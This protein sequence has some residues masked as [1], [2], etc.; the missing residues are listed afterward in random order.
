MPNTYLPGIN[1]TLNDLGL[2]IAPPPAGPKVTLLGITSNTGVTI[3]EPFTVTSLEK[4]MNT[5]YF[6]SGLASTTR[7]P[8][9]L[10]LAL[11]QANNA[12]ATNLEV[13]VIGH[14]TGAALL[15]YINPTGIP[16]QRYSDLSGA[17][18]I[19]RNRDLDV[20]VPINAWI[21]CTGI[22]NSQNF[23]KQ[24]ANFCFQA[25]QE[26]NSCIGVISVRPPLVWAAANK[27]QLTSSGSPTTLSGEVAT[28]FPAGQTIGDF[29][30]TVYFGSPSSA[31]VN[32]WHSYHAYPNDLSKCQNTFLGNFVTG[33]KYDPIYA[34]WLSGAADQNDN[35]LSEI[36]ATASAVNDAYFT[37]WQAYD[38]DG[39]AAVDSRSIKVDAGAYISVFT[40]PVAATSSTLVSNLAT[41]L[42]A[43]PSVTVYNTG[44]EAGYAGL[45]N[46]LAPQSSTTN[47]LVSGLRSVKLLSARQANDLSGM[48]HVTMYSRS[49][50]F[51][52][53]AG[54][55]GAYKVTNYIRSD[56]VNLTTVRIVHAVVDTI[57]AI[58][59]KYLGEPNN[60]PQLNALDNEV[61]QVLNTFKGSGALNSADYSISST[62]DQ[63]VLGIVEINLTLVPAFEIRT[64]NLTVSLSKD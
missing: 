1:L 15:T 4:A 28:L 20:V 60:A 59:E 51:V 64:I 53:G 16:S 24:L 55:T 46:S 8:G 40:A 37:S 36:P 18:D 19:L 14:Y 3:R 6:Q 45:V 25:T 2:K 61:D 52:V 50:G 54:N 57:R 21:D 56:Y 23:G 35:T 43:T 9:E 11:E 44:G 30:K 13:I 33:Y 29:L 27:Q 31:L 32:E 38:S 39:V 63:R 34:G 5:L 49:K 26:S 41:S 62:P 58:A 47:K 10:A 48:R 42:T 17:Y 22:A 7:F 12:G